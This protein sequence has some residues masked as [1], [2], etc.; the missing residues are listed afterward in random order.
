MVNI[1][2]KNASRINFTIAILILVLV[3]LQVTLYESTNKLIAIATLILFITTLIISK[4]YY[5]C[6][7]CKTHIT[8]ESAFKK[9]C[10]HCGAELK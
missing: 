7:N 8:R 10:P 2:Y 6:P 1:S 9:T 4:K 5:N 3:I